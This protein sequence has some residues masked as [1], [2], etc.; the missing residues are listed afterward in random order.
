MRAKCLPSAGAARAPVK[1]STSVL[2]TSR[3]SVVASAS[4]HGRERHGH[5]SVSLACR[6]LAALPAVG[7]VLAIPSAHN[8]SV[9]KPLFLKERKGC[10]GET[11]RRGGFPRAG[12]R[13]VSGGRRVA[14][15]GAEQGAGWKLLCNRSTS[16]WVYSVKLMT[17]CALVNVQSRKSAAGFAC[18]VSQS[19][20][21]N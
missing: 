7:T 21:R 19:C 8:R 1:P 20:L 5:P 18:A 11:G 12:R 17:F 10:E 2:I 6:S 14:A 13:G 16:L 9:R 15:V 3:V 4:H